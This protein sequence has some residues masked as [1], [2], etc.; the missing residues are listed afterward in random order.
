MKQKL[1]A[2]I[3]LLCSFPVMAQTAGEIRGK[4]INAETKEPLQGIAV[5][6]RGHNYTTE[7][8][9][10]G[11]FRFSEIEGT[12]DVLVITSARI[13]AKELTVKYNSNQVTWL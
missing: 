2:L 6:L 8:D 9:E 11:A 5:I 10:T 7:T 1:M 13:M 4:I 12:S 3:M